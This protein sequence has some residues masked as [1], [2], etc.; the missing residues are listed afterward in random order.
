MVGDR[1][2]RAFGRDAIEVGDWDIQ[3]YFHLRQQRF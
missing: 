1:H 2:Q 3:R